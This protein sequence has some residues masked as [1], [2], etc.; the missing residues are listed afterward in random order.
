MPAGVTG[1][2]RIGRGGVYGAA[3]RPSSVIGEFNTARLRLRP[4]RLDDIDIL[5]ELNSDPEVMRC[6][7]GRPSTLEEVVVELNAC[8][9]ARWLA[10]DR[11]GAFVGWVGAIPVAHDAEYNLG[12]RLRRTA[13]GHGFATEAA[14]VLVN[15]LFSARGPRRVFAQTMAVNER[16]RALM[17][18]IGLRYARTFHEAFDDPLPG[19]EFGEVEYELTREE[20]LTSNG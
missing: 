2:T 18:R 17:E 1:H 6:I 16:S 20:W 3:C 14:L 10:F 13:W 8:L 12:W 4:V 5:V 7:T 19:T 9:G 15:E 11:A